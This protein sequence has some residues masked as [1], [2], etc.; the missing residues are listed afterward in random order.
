MVK[1]LINALIMAAVPR[2]SDILA[3]RNKKEYDNM[4]IHILEGIL[5]IVVPISVGIV[6]KSEKIIYLIFG[7][8]YIGG[9]PSLKLLGLTLPFAVCAYLFSGVVLI[10]NHLEEKFMHATVIGAGVN[11]VL[12][13]IFIPNYGISG[14]AATTLLAEFI[15]CMLCCCYSRN[16][17]TTNPDIRL[18]LIV[19]IGSVT[20]CGICILTDIL[21][22]QFLLDLFL[23]IL[24]SAIF[25]AGII[26]LYWKKRRNCR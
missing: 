20:V 12:N 5:M 4:V 6:L 3:K 21:I 16:I 22:K 19:L 24:T 23:S 17:L 10:P 14:A 8:E 2:A 15:V 9:A 18:I 7:E 1:I 13:I 11:I 26:C 25:Y